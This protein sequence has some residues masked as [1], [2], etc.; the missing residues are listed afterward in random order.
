MMIF[1]RIRWGD[2]LFIEPRWWQSERSS[3]F[4]L[5][6]F[7]VL[8]L[9]GATQALTD[10]V[11]KDSKFFRTLHRDLLPHRYTVYPM[12]DQFTNLGTEAI[13]A[14]F[15]LPGVIVHPRS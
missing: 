1:G 10:I 13:F 14:F 2:Y 7:E 4:A 9:W 8:D 3:N 6:D 11:R 5:R 12:C 15:G